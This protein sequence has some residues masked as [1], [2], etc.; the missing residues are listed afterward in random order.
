ML[1]YDRIDVCFLVDFKQKMKEV[2]ASG[3]S[4]LFCFFHFAV[5]SQRALRW[6]ARPVTA[7]GSGVCPFGTMHLHTWCV[8]WCSEPTPSLPASLVPDGRSLLQLRMALVL[9]VGFVSGARCNKRHSVLRSCSFLEKI[10]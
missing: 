7:P 5:N 1:M 3:F 9:V 8:C 4:V 10:F 6:T 2:A